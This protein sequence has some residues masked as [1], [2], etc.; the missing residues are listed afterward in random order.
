MS[1]LFNEAN[2]EHLFVYAKIEPFIEDIRDA[3]WQS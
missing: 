1:K 3:V 2:G